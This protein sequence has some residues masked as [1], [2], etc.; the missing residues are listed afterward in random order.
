MEG[1][2]P[3]GKKEEQEAEADEW[4]AG[5]KTDQGHKCMVTF[6][7]P[8]GY[9]SWKVTYTE[10]SNEYMNKR[11]PH[12][13][14]SATYDGPNLTGMKFALSPL[15]VVQ[16]DDGSWYVYREVLEFPTGQRPHLTVAYGFETKSEAE[17]HATARPKDMRDTSGGGYESERLVFI[18]SLIHI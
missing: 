7:A 14:I 5:M 15:R 12:V 10:E 4:R 17:S 8:W 3:E 1:T 11:P 9:D 2:L 16:A 6:Q 13:T 18:L